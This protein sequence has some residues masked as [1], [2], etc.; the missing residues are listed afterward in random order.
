MCLNHKQFKLLDKNDKLQ[1]K[2]GVNQKIEIKVIIKMADFVKE[3]QFKQEV[4]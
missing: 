2:G 3:N 1:A 4:L